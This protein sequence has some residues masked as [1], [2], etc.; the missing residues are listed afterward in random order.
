MSRAK[1]FKLPE[2]T[3]NKMYLGNN[4]TVREIIIIIREKWGKGTKLEDIT[5]GS[6]HIQVQCFGY[7]LYDSG[8]YMHFVTLEKD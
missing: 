6:E 2:D 1:D 5:V 4:P 7:D 8:D 3:E